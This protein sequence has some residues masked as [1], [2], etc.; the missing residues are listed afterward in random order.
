MNCLLRTVHPGMLLLTRPAPGVQGQAV[1]S[2]RG[3]V[4]LNSIHCN[5]QAP[6]QFVV[7]GSDCTCRVYDSRVLSQA[8]G[9]LDRPVRPGPALKRTL[10]LPVCELRGSA[11]RAWVTDMCIASESPDG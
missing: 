9:S 7:G 10:Q 6:Y 3:I 2:R 11:K 1:Q 5:P 8:A 4:A